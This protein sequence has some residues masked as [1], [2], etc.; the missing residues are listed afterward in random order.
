MIERP[1]IHFR[2]EGGHLAPPPN[3]SPLLFKP[4]RLI[5]LP[6]VPKPANEAGEAAGN[7]DAAEDSEPP[8]KLEI[9]QDNSSDSKQSSDQSTSPSNLSATG[10]NSDE[11]NFANLDSTFQTTD[12]HDHSTANAASLAAGVLVFAGTR[13]WKRQATAASSSS[14]SRSSRLARKLT[15]Q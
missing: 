5:P 9:Q 8:P 12:S 3:D 4:F 15:Q 10:D 7:S 1:V 11:I 2:L 14:F 13:R 6:A